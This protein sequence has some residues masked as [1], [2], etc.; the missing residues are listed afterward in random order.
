[1]RTRKSSRAAAPCRGQVQ[2]EE[3][4]GTVRRQVLADGVGD[5]DDGTVHG[6]RRILAEQSGIG[7]EPRQVGQI[8][9]VRVADDGVTV[10]VVEVHG[11]QSRQVGE[12]DQSQQE[13]GRLHQDSL[14]H[15]GGYDNGPR[16]FGARAVKVVKRCARVVVQPSFY[17]WWVRRDL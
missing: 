6:V 2:A 10:I 16:S 1:M 15:L 7:E 9:H 13:E 17:T 3:A 11:P 4:G 12:Q 5:E 8:P 14:G